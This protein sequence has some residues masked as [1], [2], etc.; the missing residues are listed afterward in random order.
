MLLPA[1]AYAQIGETTLI[2][3]TVPQ[4]FDRGRNVSVT[5]RPRPD[6]DPIGIQAGSFRVFPRLDAGLG[7]T[8]NTYLTSDDPQSS[9][10]AYTIASAAARSDW[11]R[12]EVQAQGQVQVRRFLGESRRDE[13]AY[14][15]GTLGRLDVGSAIALTGEAQVARQFETPFSGEALSETVALSRYTRG[16]VSVRGQYQAG[17]GRA[18][19]S[20]DRTSFD[21][22][23]IELAN[24]SERSQDDRDRKINRAT[25]QLEYA[26]TPSVSVYGQ[27]QYSRVDYDRRL[28]N[29]NANRDSDGFRA[30]AGFN[31]DLAGL[32]RGTIGLGYTR[33]DYDSPLYNNVSG[34]SVEARIQYFRSE[35]TTFTLGLR[36]V[37][38]DS[39]LANSPAYFDNRVTFVVDHE[40]LRNLLLNGTAEFSRQDYIGSTL[41]SDVYRFATGA[42]YLASRTW[43]I[44]ASLSYTGRANDGI[45]AAGFDEVRGQLGV[46]LRR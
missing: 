3:P 12:H 2:T 37:I 11:S 6:Y 30:V 35:L 9:V 20:L 24:G 10:I 5:E 8:S 42:R 34:L 33:R 45:N 26:F 22:S 28:F 43:G 1:A 44:E 17:Q 15:F 39:N 36:R 46:T 19:I 32:T 16:F 4:D 41:R 23:A 25:G 40:L 27:L 13:D 29:G 38:E 18:L 7:G 21:F 14:N 31:F